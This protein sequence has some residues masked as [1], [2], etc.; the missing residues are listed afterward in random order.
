M[1]T[2]PVAL[3]T[4]PLLRTS[5]IGSV[6]SKQTFIVHYGS[7]AQTRANILA[8]CKNN[9]E[10]ALAQMPMTDVRITVNNDWGHIPLAIA[11]IVRRDSYFTALYVLLFSC[12]RTAG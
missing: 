1:A 9:E 3:N 2:L 4:N 6:G 7:D 12:P 10:L 5:F 8:L 11:K